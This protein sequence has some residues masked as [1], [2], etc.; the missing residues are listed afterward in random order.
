MT[1]SLVFN[2]PNGESIEDPNLLDLEKLIVDLPKDYWLEGSGDATLY[3]RGQN[4]TTALIV[5]PNFDFGIYVQFVAENGDKW[6]SLADRNRLNE[7]TEAAEEWYASIGLFLPPQKAWL[8]V[9]DFCLIGQRTTE[10]EWITP[11]EIPEG[12]NW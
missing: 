11:T 3:Y 1:A 8:A 9:K 6:L 5:M 12:G 2:P 10:I 7:V 4:G